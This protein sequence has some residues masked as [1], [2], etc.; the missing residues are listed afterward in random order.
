MQRV[1]QRPCVGEWWF[2][3]C[4]LLGT[5]AAGEV[6]DATATAARTGS[7]VVHERLGRQLFG[8]QN[9]PKAAAENLP[10]SCLGGTASS[11]V[12]PVFFVCC[13][14]Q[15]EKLPVCLDASLWRDAAD[16]QVT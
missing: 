14:L 7:M 6:Q 5:T 4:L 13:I 12:P 2:F 9:G 3:S 8:G 16:G 15:Q 11:A 10:E 1:K